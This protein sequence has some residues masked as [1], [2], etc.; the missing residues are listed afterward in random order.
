MQ[1]PSSLYIDVHVNAIPQLLRLQH[2]K[3]HYKHPR[4]HMLLHLATTHKIAII[5]AYAEEMHKL[6]VTA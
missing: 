5:D 1:A 3:S 4:S 6:G 2:P